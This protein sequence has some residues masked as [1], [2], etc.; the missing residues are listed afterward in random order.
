MTEKQDWEKKLDK[1]WVE[2]EAEVGEVDR[3]ELKQFICQQIVEARWKAQEFGY[4]RGLR[5]GLRRAHEEEGAWVDLHKRA[6]I[7]LAKKKRKLANQSK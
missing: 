2:P 4:Q 3:D 7:A 6:V 1:W 5:D